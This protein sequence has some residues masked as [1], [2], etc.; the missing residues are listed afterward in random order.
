LVQDRPDDRLID[1]VIFE[2]EARAEK[3]PGLFRVIF[4]G[5]TGETAAT[6]DLCEN[7]FN[8]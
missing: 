4:R 7:G 8:G 6:A 1:L 2:V 5:V 3:S